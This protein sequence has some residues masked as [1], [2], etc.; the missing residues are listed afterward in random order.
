MDKNT[1]KS[2]KLDDNLS[3]KTGR[4]EEREREKERKIKTPRNKRDKIILSNEEKNKSRNR[5]PTRE[6]NRFKYFLN[7]DNIRRNKYRK[8]ISKKK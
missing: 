1:A 3:A 8:K 7:D 4:E 6:K 5:T 2:I